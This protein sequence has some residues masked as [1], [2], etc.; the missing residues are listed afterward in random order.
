MNWEMATVL[1]G[2]EKATTLLSESSRMVTM[3]HWTERGSV[4]E[5]WYCENGHVSRYWNMCE[6]RDLIAIANEYSF[7]LAE[8][9]WRSL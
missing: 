2:S 5:C 3:R 4:Y 6:M 8:A 1:S 7:S 9:C